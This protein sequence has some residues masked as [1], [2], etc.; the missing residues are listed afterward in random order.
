M[1]RPGN[2][3]A[4]PVVNAMSVDVEDYFQ[5]SAFERHVRRDDWDVIAPRVDASIDRTLELFDRHGVRATFF[6]LG[7]VARRFPRHLERIAMAGHEVA[8]H[9]FAHH[10]V[11]DLTPEDFRQDLRQTRRLLEDVTG[12]PVRGYRAPSYSIGAS[13]PW[14]H[15]VLAEEG[16]AYSSSVYPIR[17]DHYGAPD[18]PRHPYTPE[19]GGSLVEIPVT[20]VEIAGRRFPCGGGGYFRLYPYGLSRW[21]LQRVNERE[22]RPGVFYFHPWEIDP[23]QP[24][25]AGLPARTRFRHYLNLHRMEARLER[26]LADFHWDRVDRVFLRAALEE[27]A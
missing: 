6:T 18:A 12:Q 3:H 10:R 17:H 19:A 26:L 7:W 8:S 22:G 27:A 20:T 16:Y 5:V 11:T 25:M 13:N 15:T 14:A 24:R 4:V 1:A 2:P 23:D 21:A 9:G